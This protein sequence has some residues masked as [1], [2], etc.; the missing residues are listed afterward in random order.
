M[1]RP[2]DYKQVMELTGL[3]KSY[4]YELFDRGEL[5]GFRAGRRRLFF[6]S[7]V[8]DYINR[9]RN[10][11]ARAPAPPAPPPR[12]PRRRPAAAAPATGFKFL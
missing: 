9:N 4:V 3:Q 7:G 10:A 8:Q 5:A 12:S 1:E 6:A 2:L 11:P